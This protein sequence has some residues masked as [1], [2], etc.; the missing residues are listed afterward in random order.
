MTYETDERLIVA[1]P[2][3]TKSINT[4]REWDFSRWG[5][6]NLLTGHLKVQFNLSETFARSL[7][8]PSRDDM[9]ISRLIWD[10]IPIS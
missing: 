7:R 4:P 3:Y 8:L 2:S 5:Q 1:E 9:G 10:M 6:T